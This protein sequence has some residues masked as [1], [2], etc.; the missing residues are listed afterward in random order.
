MRWFLA[1]ELSKTILNTGTTDEKNPF[2][3]LL[4][5]LNV[6]LKSEDLSLWYKQKRDFYELWLQHKQ[7]KTMEMSEA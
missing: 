3:T 7:L 2:A 4:A 5:S 1:P 6:T